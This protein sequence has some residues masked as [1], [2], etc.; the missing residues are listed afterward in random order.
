MPGKAH[1][2]KSLV[3]YGPWGHT[4]SDTTER[5]SFFLP[6]LLQILQDLRI[7]QP[8]FTTPPESL[9]RSS[10]LSSICPCPG[11]CERRTHRATQHQAPEL[12]RW[13]QGRS[14]SSFE[15]QPD[16]LEVPVCPR[17]TASTWAANSSY[18]NPASGF[19]IRWVLTDVP[20]PGLHQDE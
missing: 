15:S 20:C 19:P 10:V 3:G 13:T 16:G 17:S 2:R 11:G 18:R 8:P 1:G 4:E 9:R 6:C 14:L 7:L 12:P 5:L